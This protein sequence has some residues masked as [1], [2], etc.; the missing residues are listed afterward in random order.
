MAIILFAIS[1]VIISPFHIRNSQSKYALYHA[2]H[3]GVACCA[4]LQRCVFMKSAPTD[5]CTFIIKGSHALPL[6]WGPFMIMEFSELSFIVQLGFGSG[7]DKNA[8]DHN[9]ERE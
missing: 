4:H 8:D 3:L 2:Y 6:A 5:H 7:K 9:H 1:Q